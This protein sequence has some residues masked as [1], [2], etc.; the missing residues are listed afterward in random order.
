MHKFQYN[1]FFKQYKLNI[2]NFLT[3]TN[4]C[5]IKKL[6]K[7]SEIRV[8]FSIKLSIVIQKYPSNY[9]SMVNLLNILE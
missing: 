3:C 1:F 4:S 5:T 6:I 2:L 7:I 9:K 8:I